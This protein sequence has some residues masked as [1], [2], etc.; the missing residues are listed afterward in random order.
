MALCIRHLIPLGGDGDFCLGEKTTESGSGLE[1]RSDAEVPTCLPD[2]LV[3]AFYIW[4]KGLL[5]FVVFVARLYVFLKSCDFWPAVT[6]TLMASGSL[7]LVLHRTSY[8][9]PPISSIELPK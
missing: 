3:N 2:P 8:S 4:K 7:D 5:S 1:H 6:N 9:K